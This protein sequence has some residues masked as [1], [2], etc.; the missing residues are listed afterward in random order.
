VELAPPSSAGACVWGESGVV[1]WQV[2]A[3]LTEVG[4]HA[5]IRVVPI[6][7]GMSQQKQMRLLHTRPEVVVATPGRLWDYMSRGE[8]HLVN[9][10][11][12]TFLVIDEADRMVEKGHYAELENILARLPTVKRAA[13][14]DS[15]KKRSRPPLWK[16]DQPG[17][18]SVR[19]VQ[20][21]PI[22]LNFWSC[23]RGLPE[24]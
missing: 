10:R 7:G 21:R 12:L 19:F 14:A 8:K 23:W 6:V 22:S 17:A 2:T 5:G 9:L 3:H 20:A 13:N 4:K 18:A 16:K 15:S 11:R 24:L 1:R